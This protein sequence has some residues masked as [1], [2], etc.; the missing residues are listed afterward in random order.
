[1]VLSVYAKQRI[2]QLFYV[3]GIEYHAEIARELFAR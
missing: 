3:D 2:I 1:M